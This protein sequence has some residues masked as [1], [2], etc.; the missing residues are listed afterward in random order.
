MPTLSL[1]LSSAL[2]SS[3]EVTAAASF[4]GGI[5]THIVIRPHEIDSKAWAILFSYFAALAHLLLSY[6][7][8]CEFSAGQA[9]LR[10]IV[11]SNAFNLGLVGSIL[12]YRALF[13][14]LRRFPGPFPAKLSRFYAMKNAAKSLRANE[15]IQKLH[16]KYGDF[17]R[18]GPREISIN[19]EAAIRV[20]YEPPTQCARSPWYSQVSNDTTKISL[21]STRDLIVHKN[22]KRAW[23][24]GLGFRALAQYEERIVSKVDLLMSRIA[25]HEGIA[26]DM[27][28]YATFFGFD[29]MG[30]VG[31]SKDFDM[32]NSGNKHTAIQGLHESMGAVGVLGTVPW[33]MSMLG[34]I[35]GATG[36]YSHFMD[37]CGKELQ[38]KRG[39]VAREKAALQDQDPRDVMSWLLR[40]EEEN[41]RSAPPGEGAF[42]EDS[43][44]MIIAGSDTVAVALANAL[45]YLTRNQASYR[46]LQ[47]LVDAQFPGGEQDWTYEQAKSITCLDYIIQETLRLKPSVPAGL[48]RLTP[49]G[50]IQVDEVF[51]PAD[52]IVSVPAHTIHRDPRYW[53]NA[54]EFNPERWEGVNPEKVPWI[55][56]TRGQFACAGKNL[57]LMELKMV[58]S[59]IALRY[60]MEFPPGEDG[61]KF[62]KEAKDTFTLNVP[63]L[64]IVFTLR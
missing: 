54:L 6:V 26:I 10:T 2:K 14:R 34:K 18:V 38:T 27:T 40:A 20:L 55:P 62:D 49:A 29:V 35:P 12:T 19:R 3:L 53:E 15:E 32:L 8:L 16:E 45:Y 9:L 63:E 36:S 25:N 50:G 37:W 7:L 5:A 51:I 64:L 46:K 31:F 33:L 28:Q 59:R 21:H 30:E 39:I 24:R 4:V 42:Q 41:D 1:V 23:A 11:V 57:A 58:L 17:V 22:R 60:N 52:T 44:L 61:E 48:T 56:F 47:E 43:R 13:H